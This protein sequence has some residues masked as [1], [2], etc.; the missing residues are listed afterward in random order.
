MRALAGLLGNREG[1][2]AEF[3]KAGRPAARTPWRE[4]G[5]CA[6]DLELTGLDPRRDD[7]IAVGAV[8]IERGRV[9]LGKAAYTLVRTSK[10]SEVAAVLV[11]KLRVADLAD[12]PSLEHGIELVLGAFTGHVPV[13]HTAA[14][15]RAFL[16]RPF[17]ERRVRLPAAADTEV[18]GRAWLRARDGVTPAGISLA[19]LTNALGL[20]A[21]PPH[22]ALGDALT[23]AKAFIA[24]ATHLD[25]VAPQTVG[26][27]LNVTEHWG[28]G[29]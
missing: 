23:T 28:R 14:V 3:A 2:A 4:A 19:R 6:L 16:R 8:P 12:A 9:I 20:P 1:A 13:F 7:I 5:W 17:A 10:R 24:L 26:S 22:H 18:L 29:R 21:E 27:L 11:H 15:E 25:A